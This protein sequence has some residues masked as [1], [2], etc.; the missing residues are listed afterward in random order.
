[1]SYQ[2]QSIPRLR[3]TQSFIRISLPS[4]FKTNFSKKERKKRVTMAREET[5]VRLEAIASTIVQK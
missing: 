2:R 5:A 4:Q 3:A 1:M